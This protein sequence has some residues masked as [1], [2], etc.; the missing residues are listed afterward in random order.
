MKYYLLDEHKNLVEGYDKEGFLG[1][2][3]QA[4]EEGSLE[5]IDEDSAVASKIRSVLNGTTH[6]IEFV[7]QAQYNELEAQGKL[8]ANTYYFITDDTSY[9]DI[10]RALN[11]HADTLEDHSETLADHEERLSNQE[12]REITAEIGEYAITFNDINPYKLEIEE[13]EKFERRIYGWYVCRTGTYTGASA[14]VVFA[15]DSTYAGGSWIAYGL[16]LSDSTWVKLQGNTP[17]ITEVFVAYYKL[18]DET[19]L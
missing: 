16:E 7:T 8:V 9:A 5:N 18:T 4:I 3:E 10:D 6:H 2:L 17:K 15:Y 12:A 14:P 13:F 1:L 19:N 11:Q